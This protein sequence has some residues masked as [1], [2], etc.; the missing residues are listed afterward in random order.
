MVW[1]SGGNHRVHQ[2]T[3]DF[4]TRSTNP[5][6]AVANDEIGPA[7]WGA[8]V[9]GQTTGSGYTQEEVR[10]YVLWG[11]LLAGGFGVEYYYG[12]STGCSDLTCEDHRSRAN[13]YEKTKYAI[14]FFDQIPNAIVP[15]LENLNAS[16]N[17]PNHNQNRYC[18]GS[19]ADLFYLVYLHNGGSTT[20]NLPA[21]GV[22]TYTVQWFNPRTG[23]TNAPIAL[24][25]N[26][27]ALALTAP[28]A[29]N[30]WTA[31][32]EQAAGGG[33]TQPIVFY[34]D[35][36]NDGLGQPN[37]TIHACVPTPPYTALQ[38]GACDDADATVQGPRVFYADR[39][40]DGAGDASDSALLC[41]P[42][43]PYAALKGDDCDDN[44]AAVQD[45]CCPISFILV[46]AST[47]TELFTIV[48]NSII[49]LAVV[50]T[51]LNIRADIGN[52]IGVSSVRFD[53]NNQLNYRTE[54]V[55]PYALAGDISGNYLT[56]N[57]GNSGAHKVT[58]RAFSGSNGR[59][60]LLGQCSVK[61][62]FVQ[63]VTPDLKTLNQVEETGQ[64]D[65]SNGLKVYPNPTHKT[66][67]VE[68]VEE[69]QQITVFNT[70]GQAVYQKPIYQN[71][72]TVHLPTLPT[73]VYTL[74][75][76]YKKETR[77]IKLSL[78]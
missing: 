53:W 70:L 56:W 1:N 17:N 5:K 13:L 12:Y 68:S 62:I 6:W 29:N 23:Q 24:T 36:D 39:D 54:N 59:G 10:K 48:P 63:P 19:D 4:V 40:G 47:N 34:R 76:K 67:T 69:V 2:V 58:A 38:G 57:Y 3:R 60:T 27:L 78:L 65:A 31:R 44:N 50:G 20:L 15:R 37:D 33:C 14:Q 32:I 71:L 30:D 72:F 35:N 9:D 41:Q 18:L 75:L 43:D 25:S 46:D 77:T 16:V 8:P 55:A 74:V 11:H 49:N 73:G 21:N 7:S 52:L 42:N 61:F 22:G 66:F 45:H 28:T 51:N 64:L 26:G